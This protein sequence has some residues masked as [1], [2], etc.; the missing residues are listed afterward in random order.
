MVINQGADFTILDE[1]SV[2][3]LGNSMNMIDENGKYKNYQEYYIKLSNGNETVN[4]A[5]NTEGMES[6]LSGLPTGTFEV[7]AAA[8]HAPNTFS[9]KLTNGKEYMYTSIVKNDLEIAVEDGEIKIE[10]NDNGYVITAA[11]ID[12]IGNENKYYFSGSLGEIA[13]QHFAAQATSASFVG[14]YNTYYASGVNQ[15]SI[16]LLSNSTVT[17]SQQ[18][19]HYATFNLNGPTG[20][21]SGEELPTGTFTLAAPEDRT[22][23][24]WASG[25][26]DAQSNTMSSVYLYDVDTNWNYNYFY[27]DEGANVVVDKN[28]DG[29]YNFSFHGKAALYVYDDNYNLVK[30]GSSFDYEYSYTHVAVTVDTQSSLKPC[31]DGDVEFKTVMSSQYVG[32]WWGKAYKETYGTDANVFTFGFSNVNGIYTAYL[33][34]VDDN[35]WTWTG[36]FGS[37][38]LYCNT[39]FAEGTYNFSRTPAKMTLVPCAYSYVQN[40]YS[41]TKCPITGGYIMLDGS[42]CYYNLTVANPDDAS[43]I[44]KVTGSH[45]ASLY[46][47][48]NYSAK[49]KA[50]IA[51]TE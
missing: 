12:Q 21:I 28:D 31:P 32:L 25:I 26:L 5:V 13:D 2:K 18:L 16:T 50:L 7:D 23:L 9:I 17:G 15:W 46:Y 4:L 24:N 41:G 40:G 49:N 10:K 33:T 1:S 37:T 8:N 39:P 45:D 3:Y 27:F 38:S 11:L 6:P 42:K 34:V 44:Y 47:L 43:V 29:T 19:F 51:I 35:N 14:Q 20:N 22:D 36:N 48:R 30:S